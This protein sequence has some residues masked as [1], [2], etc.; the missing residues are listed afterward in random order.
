MTRVWLPFSNALELYHQYV[1]YPTK[2][3]Q[4]AIRLKADVKEWLDEKG[5]EPAWIM[6]NP[7]E[8]Y[9]DFDDANQAMLFKLTW[10]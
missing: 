9:F 7:W 2:T 3:Y 10:A 6:N 5:W 1:S 4:P 8:C